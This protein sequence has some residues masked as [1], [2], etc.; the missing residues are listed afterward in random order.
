MDKAVKIAFDY[1]QPFFT[2]TTSIPI[3]RSRLMRVCFLISA[4]ILCALLNGCG[5]V[6][7]AP[8]QAFSQTVQ[9]LK[10]GTDKALEVNESMSSDRFLREALQTTAKGDPKKVN[11]LRL[12]I[13]ATKPFSFGTTSIP[14]F[15]KAQQF[16]QSTT[17]AI[18]VFTS[19]SDLLLRL[20]SPELLPRETFDKMALDLN[21]NA[22]DAALATSNEIPDQEKV[23]LFSTIAVALTREYLESKRRSK[24]VDALTANQPTVDNFAQHMRNGVQIAATHAAQEYDEE[25][26]ELFEKMTTRTGPAPEPVRREAIQQLIELDRK[27]IQQLS[28]L[29]S[30]HGA[31]GQIPNAHAELV[32][33][34]ENDDSKL[35][36]T[37]GLFEEGKRLESLYDR[38]LAVNKGKAAQA[39]AD[40]ATALADKLDAEAEAA[41]L[42]A[43]RAIADALKAKSVAE[44][45][46]SDERKKAR[47]DETRERAEK[48]KDGALVIKKKAAEA[49]T[50]T[51]EAQKQVDEIKKK[52][53][54]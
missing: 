37:V 30:L 17:Q 46:P 26:Q 42:R 11:Q 32:K 50:S 53:P 2:P 52:L 4:W 51:N 9:Q 24:L 47:A 34:I 3:C 10:V 35:P 48:L 41:Q 45:D 22:Y 39:I 13:D 21:A 18:G 28:V 29:Q 49:R 44:A 36:T 1:Q 5:T 54:T 14:L 33:A 15:M 12:P 19:Y 23:A 27:Y 40:R 20:S 16:R 25:S 43:D 6:K 38:S 31:F 7:P 8:F